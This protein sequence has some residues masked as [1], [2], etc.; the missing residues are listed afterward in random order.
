MSDLR[1]RVPGHSL[2]DELLRQWDL[3]TIHIDPESDG[4]VIDDE[5][6]GWYRGVIGERRVGSLL[7]HLGSAWTVLHSV[8]IGRGAS[9]IDHIVIGQAGVFTINT[10]YSPGKEVWV[11]DHVVQLDRNPTDFLRNSRFEAKRASARLTAAAGTTIPV[12]GLI[13]FVDPGRLTHASPAGDR[14]HDPT[15]EVLRDSELLAAF[16]TRPIFSAEQV[17]RIV[18]NA[19]VPTTWHDAPAPSTIGRHISLEFEALEAAV[20]PRL[21]QPAARPAPV[22]RPVRQRAPRYPVA[23]PAR[24]SAPARRPPRNRKPRQSPLEKLFR[25][26]VV[27]AAMF[28]VAWGVLNYMTHR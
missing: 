8:P 1:Q 27:P 17:Q 10:K 23:S 2:V 11:G 21:A 13:V 4:I 28:A 16:A 7:A 24:R 20:G 15:V 5:A 26:L 3:G 6:V 9:D 12:T 19:V 25:G 14:M 18:E 22:S